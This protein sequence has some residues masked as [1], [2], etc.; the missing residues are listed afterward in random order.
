MNFDDYQ[1]AAR[2]TRDPLNQNLIVYPALGLGGESGEVLEV[3][4]KGLRPGGFIDVKKVVLEMGD[5]LWYLSALADDLGTDLTTIA[6]LN[7][8]KLAERHGKSIPQADGAH[9]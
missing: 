4:K 2:S 6:Q 5:V 9:V 1:A 8:E 7:I 3:I